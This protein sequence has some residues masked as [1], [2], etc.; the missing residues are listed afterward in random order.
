MKTALLAA[1]LLVGSIPPEEPGVLV[2]GTLEGTWEQVSGSVN[3]RPIP[4]RGYTW[5]FKGGQLRILVNGRNN[6]TYQY[7]VNTSTQPAS[8]D[9]VKNY[10]G[11]FLAEGDSLKLCLSSKDRP[12][13]FDGKGQGQ[14]IYTF[15]LSSR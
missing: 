15:R 1:V 6:V 3:G 10:Q 7:T 4:S 12:A 13:S 8:I 11:I 5:I 14:E 2:P 9:L